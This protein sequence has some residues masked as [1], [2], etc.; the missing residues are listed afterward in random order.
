MAQSELVNSIT[1]GTRFPFMNWGGEHKY[2]DHGR[3]M[4]RQMVSPWKLK[5]SEK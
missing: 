1:L 5:M 2:E 3:I 4:T